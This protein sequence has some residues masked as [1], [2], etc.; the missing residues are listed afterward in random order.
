MSPKTRA[1]LTSI[2]LNVLLP[3]SIF[4]A[5]QRGL[6]PE[7]LRWG[8]VVFLAAVGMQVL[9]FLL[10]KF[11]Y[12]WIPPGRRLVLKYATMTNN[13]SFMGF[14]VLGGIF[15]EIGILYGSIF[16][17]PM[18]I[19]SWT[20]GLPLFTDLEARERVVSLVTNPCMVAVILGIG[21]VFVPFELPAFLTETIA[22]V[23]YC[24]RVM[25]M[26]IVGSIL[27][28]VKPKEVLDIHCFYYSF[29]RLIAIPAIMFGVL[30]LL[31]IDPIAISVTVLM[32]GMPSAVLT[33]TLAE[34]YGKEPEFASKIVFVSIMLSIV[35]LPLIAYGLA[36][37]GHQ[38]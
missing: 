17:I 21:Y 31:D 4:S 16:I 3:C 15:G 38:L 13:A 12:N 11:L 29:F 24:V 20:S 34:K 7:I 8:L 1:D 23:G 22:V 30:T 6:T 37:W 9:T 36:W 28:G 35:T 27:H 26:L 33:A 19:M 18:R 14:S 10:N 25:P 2:V 5:Y 32:A